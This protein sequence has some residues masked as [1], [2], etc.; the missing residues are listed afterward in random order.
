TPSRLAAWRA[1]DHAIADALAARGLHH[2]PQQ[3]ANDAKPGPP[4]ELFR[5]VM[6][7]V[8]AE[9]WDAAVATCTRLLKHNSDF[10]YTLNNRAWCLAKLGRF[11][12]ASADIDRAIALVERLAAPDNK[13]QAACYGTRGLIF[14]QTRQYHAAIADLSRALNI[15]PARIDF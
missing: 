14:L 4:R 6:R 3:A 12:E 8:Q 10:P 13:L 5:R 9:K 11:E 2:T 15:H 1:I 7:E